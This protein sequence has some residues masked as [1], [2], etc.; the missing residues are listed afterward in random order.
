MTVEGILRFMNG[1]ARKRWYRTTTL[2]V[3]EGEFC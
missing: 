1:F 2:L 3:D